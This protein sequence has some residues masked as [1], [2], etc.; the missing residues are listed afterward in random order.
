[1][2]RRSCIDTVSALFVPSSGDPD[3]IQI[4]QHPAYATGTVFLVHSASAPSLRWSRRTLPV[5]S[6]LARCGYLPAVFDPPRMSWHQGLSNPIPNFGLHLKESFPAQPRQ[7]GS[8]RKNNPPVTWGMVKNLAAQATVL[9]E[10]E[11]K[12]KT[13]E[14]FL[15][16]VF[17][18]L[19]ANSCLILFCYFF[20]L[21]YV[22]TEALPLASLS[23]PNMWVRH[24]YYMFHTHGTNV[25]L[26]CEHPLCISPC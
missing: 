4:P 5:E 6:Q 10:Q 24:A 19:N 14:N 21:F 23:H 1:M 20:C 11:E 18:A 26:I 15:A 9:L 12:E 22:P 25:S 16:A 17:A 2:F 3:V 8:N 7:R 13:P